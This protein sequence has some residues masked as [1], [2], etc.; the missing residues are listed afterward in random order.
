MWLWFQ[1]SDNNL[2]LTTGM[3][4]E[5]R[6]KE[7]GKWGKFGKVKAYK[8]KNTSIFNKIITY[9]LDYTDLKCICCYQINL[10]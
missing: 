4:K 8:F 5:R 7:K 9:Q 6:R 3:K 1:K 10:N 2:R